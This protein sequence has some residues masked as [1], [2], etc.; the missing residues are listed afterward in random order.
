MR[1]ARIAGGALAA[2]AITVLPIDA[3]ADHDSPWM[4]RARAIGVLPQEDAE[5]MPIGGNV[6]ID[7]SLVPELDVTY[8]FDENWA[9]E[10]VL[11][12][13][14]HE[15]KHKPT[16]LDLGDVWLL[17]PTLTLQYH[18]APDDDTIRPYLGAGVNYTVFFNVDDGPL[19]VNYSNEF[20]FALQAGFDI[21]LENGWSINADV[22]KIFLSTD[23]SVVGVARAEV[24]INPWIVGL[25]VGYRY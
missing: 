23:V 18:F 5:V 10:L 21:P 20:G 3:L 19:T 25:G 4:V 2:V 7:D 24:E 8:F 17:P 1:F 9:A 12:V 11:A 6:E 14:P 13:T 15:A 22:K 16:N